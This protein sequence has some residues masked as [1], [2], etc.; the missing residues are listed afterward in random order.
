MIIREFKPADIAAAHALWRSTEGVCNCEKCMFLDSEANL[1]KYMKRNPTSCFIAETDGKLAGT[2]LAGHDGRTGLIYRLAVS[3]ENRKK[4]LGRALV[5]KA[6]EALKSE[7]IR[8]V[9][10]FVLE[11]N[12]TGNIFWDKIGFKV[13]NDAVTRSMKI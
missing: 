5:D 3:K 8:S 2:I 6:L 12:E 7:G 9:L 4:G 11:S 1:T 13:G 10:A